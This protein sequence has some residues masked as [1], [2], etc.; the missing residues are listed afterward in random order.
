MVQVFLNLI[1]RRRRHGRAEAA[2]RPRP[3]PRAVVEVK[4]GNGK[5]IPD[6]DAA[7]I[8]QPYF[9][10]KKNGTGLGLFV[11][12]KLI[13]D[14]G[15]TISFRSTADAGTEFLVRLPLA[16]APAAAPIDAP[17]G[18]PALLQHSLT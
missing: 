4:Y 1:Q 9:T 18:D 6:Q 12:Q 10:T 11:T 5:D 17:A 2:S 3:A 16:N 7:K 13:V 8:F 15:G 14:H